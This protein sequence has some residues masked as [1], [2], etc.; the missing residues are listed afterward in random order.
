MSSSTMFLRLHP[1]SRI[2]HR[3]TATA[4]LQHTTH[5]LLPPHN[6]SKLSSSPAPAPLG[7]NPHR[8]RFFSTSHITSSNPIPTNGATSDLTS[9]HHH[10]S[11]WLVD[12]SDPVRTDYDAIMMLGGG[13]WEGG[14]LPPW[15]IRRLEGALHLYEHQAGI[16]LF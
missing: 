9:D 11:G 3:S 6:T 5:S 12:A 7:L 16:V 1:L 13:L 4:L 2:D 15:V 10:P 8:S 14:K